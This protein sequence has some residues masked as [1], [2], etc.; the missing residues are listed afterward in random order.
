MLLSYTTTALVCTEW[1]LVN[2]CVGNMSYNSVLLTG[3]T[4][5]LGSRLAMTLH[6]KLDVDLTATVRRCIETP[7]VRIV[8]VQDLD[9]NTDWSVALTNQQV[10]IHAAALA[11]TMKYEHADQLAE[12]RKVN[13][14]GTLNLARQAARQGVRR[15]IFI[16]SINVNGLETVLDSPI[17]ACS[18]PSP[19]DITGI[20]KYEAEQGLQ[21]IA[22]E[23]SMEVVIIRPALVYGPGVKGNF[24]SMIQLVEKGLPLPLGAIYNKRSLVAID[25]LVDLIITCIDHP[26]ATNQIFLAADGEDLSTTELLRGV[27]KAAGKPSRLFPVPAALLKLTATVLGKRAVTDRLL[28]SLQVDISKAK[29]LLCWQPP[30]SVEEGLRRCFQVSSK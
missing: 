4:G 19:S 13:V 22:A 21:K 23:T 12:Y 7:P 28:G 20:T 16:S 6:T 1:I 24:A 10:V 18:A 30:V 15:F 2:N 26:A 8:R 9:S 17:K 14:D 27:A 25:N 29:T 3:V 11:H 5:F